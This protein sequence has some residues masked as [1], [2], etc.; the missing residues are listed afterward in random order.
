MRFILVIAALLASTVA[1]AADS[2]IIALDRLP[3]VNLR[4]A[5]PTGFCQ[6]D[7]EGTEAERQEFQKQEAL[8]QN[9]RLLALFMD[10]VSYGGLGIGFAGNASTLRVITPL[11]DGRLISYAGQDRRAAIDAHMAALTEEALTAGAEQTGA[12][13]GVS[14]ARLELLG[15]DN[16]AFYT[17][18]TA[19][20]DIGGTVFYVATL[21]G[22][23]IVEDTM[24]GF[25]R[26]G[27]SI[28][29]DLHEQ[30]GQ[31]LQLIVQEFVWLNEQAAAAPPA[32]DAAA[33][34]QPESPANPPPPADAPAANEAVANTGQ[35]GSFAERLLQASGDP[36]APPPPLPSDQLVTI[37]NE[38]SPWANLPLAREEASAPSTSPTVE[39]GGAFA[40]GLFAGVL[41]L[42]LFLRRKPR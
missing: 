30:L 15:R 16:V 7:P 12:A 20:E 8:L 29:P 39:L 33:E 27:R 31:E 10:C 37:I 1:R 26:S 17:R 25:G 14:E 11:R 41:G 38:P 40:L 28:F 35:T 9:R 21:S 36:T 4:M 22:L 2:E 19:R 13:M 24:I 18:F 3:E 32:E 42:F 23:T 6:V 5:V 34:P